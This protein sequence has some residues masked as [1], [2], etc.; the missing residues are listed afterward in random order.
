[1][2]A[3]STSIDR[4]LDRLAARLRLQVFVSTALKASV[5]ASVIGLVTIVASHWLAIPLIATL[6]VLY[7]T[8]VIGAGVWAAR[9][10]LSPFELARI[11]EERLGL[12]ERLSSALSFAQCHA[13]ANE[14]FL[15]LQERDAESV[16]AA[17]GD[18]DVAPLHV[19]REA[20][21]A[22]I[23]FI[24]LLVAL[25]INSVLP[26]TRQ[27]QAAVAASMLA[28]KALEDVAHKVEQATPPGSPAYTEAQRL[29]KLAKRMQAGTPASESKHAAQKLTEDIAKRQ[30]ELAGGARQEPK[31]PAQ[32]GRD[33]ASAMN[34]GSSP[35][36]GT[37]AGDAAKMVNQ[38]AADMQRTDNPETLPEV[39]RKLASHVEAHGNTEADR[40]GIGSQLQKLSSGLEGAGLTET[41]KHIDAASKALASGDKQTAASELRKAADAAEREGAEAKGLSE[42]RKALEEQS[43]KM[44]ETQQ[45]GQSQEAGQQSAQQSGSQQSGQQ[46][47]GQE[48]S[49]QQGGQQGSPQGGQQ[50]GS[51]QSGGQAQG[52]QSGQ[53]GQGSE[54]QGQGTQKDGQSNGSQSGASSQQN[55]SGSGGGPS[56]SGG[57]DGGLNSPGKFTPSGNGPGD[58]KGN[59]KPTIG[60]PKQINGYDPSHNTS[61]ARV[62]IPQQPGGKAGQVQRTGQLLTPPLS[63]QGSQV[64]YYKAYPAAKKSAEEA[65]QRQSVPPAYKRTVDDYFR[66]IAPKK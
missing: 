48:S 1:M 42:M 60:A 47:G 34:G 63:G 54:G 29:A 53:D 3:A 2:V 30:R 38:G 50:N 18:A 39:L 58:G 21:W 57:G 62:T 5:I 56:D 46:S 17:I 66:N 15:R 43:R 51:Q 4:V 22:A 14:T 19:A 41:K 11:A 8:A 37:A 24:V 28:G 40:K 44:Q 49:G 12:K 65:L 27:M 35:T 33:I 16:A 6:I 61:S 10:S 26:S 64:P 7:V 36:T 59:S 32:T 52:N 25:A 9:A 55:G 45:S 23:A 13:A 20:R 31:S